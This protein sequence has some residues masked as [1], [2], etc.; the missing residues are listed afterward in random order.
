MSEKNED[1]VWQQG[2]LAPTTST[3]LATTE[4]RYDTML[5]TMIFCRYGTSDK[6][7]NEKYAGGEGIFTFAGADFVSNWSKLPF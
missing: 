3:R 2:V 7:L 5:S 6:E 1:G 4:L